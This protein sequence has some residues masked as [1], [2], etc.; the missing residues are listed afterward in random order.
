ME[1]PTDYNFINKSF[2]TPKVAE[3]DEPADPVKDVTPRLRLF[4]NGSQDFTSII[5]VAFTSADVKES[6]I[7]E[8]RKFCHGEEDAYQRLHPTKN[9]RIEAKDRWYAKRIFFAKHMGY[10]PKS[11]DKLT[12]VKRGMGPTPPKTVA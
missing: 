5:E 6:Y 9:S 4:V 11:G 8:E 7:K 3:P 1:T 2:M 10:Y 12:W